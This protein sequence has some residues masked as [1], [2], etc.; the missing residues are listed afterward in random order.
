MIEY[1]RL[2]SGSYRNAQLTDRKVD[3]SKPTG[4]QWITAS[5][6]D[7]KITQSQILIQNFHFAY[8]CWKTC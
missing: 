8:S 5:T 7:I 6:M 2:T 1:C 3:Q 4:G